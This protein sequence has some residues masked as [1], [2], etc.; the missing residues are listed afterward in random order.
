MMFG[1]KSDKENTQKSG[2]GRLF[3][4]VSTVD[5][6]E[7]REKF[8]ATAENFIQ[9]QPGFILKGPIYIIFI[10]LFTAVIYSFYAVVDTKV[11]TTLAV[12]GEE[13]IVQSPVAG[14]VG[15]V[16]VEQND[17][18]SYQ[19]QL[20]SI[21]SESALASEYD[22]E[23]LKVELELLR[24]KYLQVDVSI[25]KIKSI[26]N[27]YGGRDGRFVV[28][29]ATGLRR[30][31]LIDPAEIPE[32]GI[33]DS[34]WK[35][36]EY[37]NLVQKLSANS[38]RLWNS[39]NRSLDLEKKQSAIYQQDII[40]F[41][42][43]VITEYQIAASREKYLGLVSQTE[44][45]I[46]SYRVE[47]YSNLQLL[48]DL[49]ESIAKEYRSTGSEVKELEILE[50]EVILKDR[51]VIMKS[52]YPGVVAEI[53]PKSYE[54]I[55]KGVSLLRIIRDDLPKTGMIY[56][57]DQ[58]VGKVKKGQTV[59][60]KFD[61]YPY[62]DFGIQL[63][64]VIDISPDPQVVEGYGLVYESKVVF[65]KINPKINLKYGMRGV[66]EVSTGSKRMIET[67][68]APISKV[69]DYIRGKKSD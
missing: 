38:D 30:N 8:S 25:E 19:Q 4:P 20:L 66:A 61:A 11:T 9:T 57:S 67:V 21:M 3:R 31:G 46:N 15:S 41:D 14:S 29:F 16:F 2:H 56:I 62:Q 17:D 26:A 24:K 68:F 59:S 1:K 51:Q 32:N 6:M 5:V 58:N 55:G 42:K 13:Y 23:E 47:I 33:R 35:A 39:Y 18:V 53:Y 69:F 36:S 60:I 37:F 48:D 64:R 45:L 54:Y 34:I 65:D 50:D 40:L 43:K 52:K 44:A 10:I 28:E 7:E 63:G 22:L 12:L 49:L 27:D